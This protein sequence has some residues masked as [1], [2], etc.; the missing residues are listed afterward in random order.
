MIKPKVFSSLSLHKISCSP[1]YAAISNT[2][3]KAE[4]YMKK[5]TKNFLIMKISLN[6]SHT[7]FSSLYPLKK[8]H[9]LLFFSFYYNSVNDKMS[10]D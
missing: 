9:L 4:L 5:A 7:S 3:C 6:S 1:K 2:V 10:I 8:K